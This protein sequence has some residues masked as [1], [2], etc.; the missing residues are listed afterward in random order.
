MMLRKE[1]LKLLKDRFGMINS[2]D[3][4]EFSPKNSYILGILS[5]ICTM[6]KASFL[7]LRQSKLR[8]EYGKMGYS[9]QHMTK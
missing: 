1:A 4:R 3:G 2:M 6:G 8:K 9:N 7:T 5:K